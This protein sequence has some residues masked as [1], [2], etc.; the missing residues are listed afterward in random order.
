M[1][2][3]YDDALCEYMKRRNKSVILVDIASS[4]TSDFDVTE[5]YM[6][7]IST[8]HAE[9]LLSSNK[10]YRREEA[11]VGCMIFPPYHMHIADKVVLSLRSFLFIKW[12]KYEG[13][14]L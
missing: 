12:I 14:R 2:I 6:R 11:P 4:N 10:G 8:G 5:M 13:L 1:N 7:F 9:R 3:I